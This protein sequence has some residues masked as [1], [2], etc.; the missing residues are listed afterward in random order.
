M[1]KPRLLAFWTDGKN[2]FVNFAQGFSLRGGLWS[3]VALHICTDISWEPE[4]PGGWWNVRTGDP[5]VP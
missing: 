1:G 2:N 4:D 3:A 5:M